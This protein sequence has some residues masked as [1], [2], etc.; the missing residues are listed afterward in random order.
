MPV[1]LNR[2]R[3]VALLSHRTGSLNKHLVA[4]SHP[5]QLSL[6]DLFRFLFVVVSVFKP[7][8]VRSTFRR[9]SENGQPKST[10]SAGSA[11]RQSRPERKKWPPRTN[12]TGFLHHVERVQFEGMLPG[13]KL[14]N[15][16]CLLLNGNQTPNQRKLL[17]LNRKPSTKSKEHFCLSTKQAPPT[18]TP[19]Q[20]F[21]GHMALSPFTLPGCTRGS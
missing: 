16:M 6:L 21:Q 4:P 7:L 17:P 20:L 14:N 13:A 18:V 12:V 2:D 19:P 11:L 15:H 1:P 8:K 5:V 9:K 3:S 10:P